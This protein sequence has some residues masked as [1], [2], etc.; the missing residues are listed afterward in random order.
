MSGDNS[1]SQYDNENGEDSQIDEETLRE[2]KAMAVLFF[3]SGN[4]P[5]CEHGLDDYIEQ[6]K[7]NGDDNEQVQSSPVFRR[8]ISLL[9]EI[10]DEMLNLYRTNGG[11][12]P[13]QQMSMN[14]LES[15]ITEIKRRRDS[16]D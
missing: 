14:A 1:A 13:R 3:V 5:L 10:R 15:I 9:P 12:P 7:R 4:P 8:Y 11:H 6:L 16:T 2:A